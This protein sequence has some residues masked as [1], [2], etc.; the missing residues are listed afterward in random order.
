MWLTLLKQQGKRAIAQFSWSIIGHIKYFLYVKIFTSWF[1]LCI[2]P[3]VKNIF[4]YFYGGFSCCCCWFS[5]LGSCRQGYRGYGASS[6][7]GQLLLPTRSLPSPFS[8][9][10]GWMPPNC[11]KVTR[12]AIFFTTKP[13]TP[14]CATILSITDIKC[15]QRR[16]MLD[17][18]VIG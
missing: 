6:S 4:F 3:P 9:L 5:L 14:I 17:V 11:L 1:H 18:K 10:I 13:S 16:R 8:A 15:F 12:T 7:P 2:S